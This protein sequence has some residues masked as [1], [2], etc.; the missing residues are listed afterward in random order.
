MHEGFECHH[1]DV[2]GFAELFE[3]VEVA[4]GHGFLEPTICVFFEGTASFDGIVEIVP[5]TRGVVHDVDVIATDAP[6]LAEPV[7]ILVNCPRQV[8]LNSGE[9]NRESVFDI[10]DG[11]FERASTAVVVV[12]GG[13]ISDR[14][15]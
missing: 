7:D 13:G 10:F 6:D 15:D 8:V 5:S 2:E 4:V 3:A 11:G 1:G 12:G 14:A 9:A